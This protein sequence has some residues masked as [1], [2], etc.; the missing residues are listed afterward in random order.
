MKTL[1]RQNNERYSRGI[2]KKFFLYCVILLISIPSWAGDLPL[3]GEYDEAAFSN[4]EADDFNPAPSA[5]FIN[6]SDLDSSTLPREIYA[7]SDDQARSVAIAKSIE[8]YNSI[9]RGNLVS[10]SGAFQNAVTILPNYDPAIEGLKKIDE[11]MSRD[12]EQNIL[13][14]MNRK[15]IHE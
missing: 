11:K 10:A 8:G 3:K 4:L 9:E 15:K 12:V 13:T 6:I 1:T 14:L 2:E 5:N 7:L